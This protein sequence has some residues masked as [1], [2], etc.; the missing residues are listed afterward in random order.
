MWVCAD[1]LKEAVNFAV[2]PHVSK[3]RCRMKCSLCEKNSIVKLHFERKILH[4]PEKEK[5]EVE[6]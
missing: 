2:T 6:S 3:P 1:H 5:A 4:Y